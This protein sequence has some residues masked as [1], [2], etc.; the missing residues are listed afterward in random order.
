MEVIPGSRSEGPKR[1][2]KRM[3]KGQWQ[4][5][6]TSYHSVKLAFSLTGLPLKNHIMSPLR[7]NIMSPPN[8]ASEDLGH[9]SINSHHPLVG[10]CHR[11]IHF[12]PPSSGHRH[13]HTN[14]SDLCSANSGTIFQSY[15][16]N[17]MVQ[18]HMMWP[19]KR[20]VL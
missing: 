20:H 4:V 14:L 11:I 10:S 15:S 7:N 19:K 12:Y 17:Y 6:W 18:Q 2:R 9:L 13:T 16:W 8:W 3:R 1:V 5:P